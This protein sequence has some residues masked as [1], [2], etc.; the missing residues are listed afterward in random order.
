ME[1][2]AAGAERERPKRGPVKR[3]APV[4]QLIHG[5]FP[6]HAVDYEWAQSSMRR[7]VMMDCSMV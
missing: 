6:C 4:Y 3:K 2:E 5:G 1:K 7:T